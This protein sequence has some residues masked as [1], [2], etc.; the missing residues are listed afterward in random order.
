[1]AEDGD[2]LPQPKLNVSGLI[3]LIVFYLIIFAAGILSHKVLKRK[4]RKQKQ[5][6][7]VE[8]NAEDMMLA[9]RDINYFVGIFTMTATWVGGGY[10][11][12]TTESVIKNGLVWTQAPIGYSIS[13]FLGGILFAEKMRTMSFVTMLDPL[14][15]KY[16]KPLGALFYIPAFSGEILWSASILAALG[17]S[18]RVICGINDTASII[19][20]AAIAMTY[21]LFGGL[22]SVAFTDIIQLICIFVGLIFSIPWMTGHDAVTVPLQA[23]NVSMFGPDQPYSK[24]YGKLEKNDVGVWID[25]AI[26]LIFG[27]I[28]W[29]AYFQRVLSARSVSVAKTLSFCA[30]FGCFCAAIPSI[31]IG[32]ITMNTDWPNTEY[33]QKLV[34]DDYKLAVPLT[35]LYL[36]PPAVAFIGLGAVSAAVMSSTDSSILGVSTMFTRN[37]FVNVFYQKASD[38]VTVWFLRATILV[39]TIIAML[40]AIFVKTVYG[41]YLI[42]SDLVFILLFPHLVLV[43]HFPHRTNK[44]GMVLGFSI[45]LLLRV[46]SG[47]PVLKY[48]AIIKWAGYVE[49]STDSYGEPVYGRQRFPFRNLIMALNFIITLSTTWVTQQLFKRYPHLLKY[50]FLDAQSMPVSPMTPVQPEIRQKETSS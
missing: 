47:E 32:L 23:S 14:Q 24:F 33:A 28:P 22:Y 44:Y 45:A 40:I 15:I 8:S 42:C 13:L 26:M 2:E 29:Q 37:V 7:Q 21:T 9:G 49:P 34:K 1:M 30:A 5:K 4:S 35:L 48:N 3:G 31:V 41:L 25:Y 19:V 17:T 39:N 16:G 50:D 10:I 6:E 18:L 27:G 12:G 20:S 38:R 43:V 36:T 46:L 11:N